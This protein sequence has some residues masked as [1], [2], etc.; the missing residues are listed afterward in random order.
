VRDLRA[1]RARLAPPVSHP[2][3]CSVCMRAPRPGPPVRSTVLKTGD[4]SGIR[5]P[6]FR[7]ASVR[8]PFSTRH[9]VD[10]MKHGRPCFSGHRLTSATLGISYQTRKRSVVLSHSNPD[11]GAF[12]R[13]AVSLYPLHSHAERSARGGSSIVAI[14]VFTLRFRTRRSPPCGPRAAE[15]PRHLFPQRQVAACTVLRFPRAERSR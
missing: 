11:T 14:V 12:G 8:Q 3:P 6:G 9:T 7:M 4:R 1:N 13:P 15:P 2:C 5:A 10:R